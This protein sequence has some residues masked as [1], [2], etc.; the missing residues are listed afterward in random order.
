MG[1]R[2]LHL[3]RENSELFPSPFHEADLLYRYLPVSKDVNHRGESKKRLIGSYA[4][5]IIEEIR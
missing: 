1:R 4:A 2:D 5:F 3:N